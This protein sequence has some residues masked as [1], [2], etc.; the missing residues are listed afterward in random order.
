[1]HDLQIT[2]SRALAEFQLLEEGLRNYI[3]FAYA[4]I[5]DSTVGLIEFKYDR[6]S[7]DGDSLGKLIDKFSR[8]NRNTALIDRLKKAVLERNRLAH[9]GLL[10]TLNDIS[11]LALASR[12]AKFAQAHKITAALVGEVIGEL[13][14]LEH[15]RKCWSDDDGNSK[16]RRRHLSSVEPLA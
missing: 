5:Q 14:K 12:T 16:R 2:A 13:M 3:A 10:L 6:K 9:E 15:R 8:L 7:L 11:R 4:T 1:M